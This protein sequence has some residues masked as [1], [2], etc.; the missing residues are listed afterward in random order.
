MLLVSYHTVLASKNNQQS[1]T[2]GA[3]P[4]RT[5]VAFGD[6]L[7]AGYGLP[8]GTA[9]PDVLGALLADA[10]LPVSIVNAGVSGDTSAGGKA[11]IAWS[12]A[13]KPDVL[14]LALGA[15]DGLQGL[16]PQALKQNLAAIIE[17]CLEDNV[18]V[19]L[20]GMLAPQ[21]MGEVYG[22]AFNAVYPE[23]AKTY[24]LPLYPFLLKGVALDPALNL[25]D[26]I[27]PNEAGARHIAENLLPLIAGTLRRPAP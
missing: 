20:A 3:I 14:I 25:E 18:Q 16:S 21:N 27:H 7:T 2:D 24:A 12:L 13:A 4:Q 23:L 15:N 1:E 9:W 8:A 6:S 22:N 5:V 19:I 10:G 26:G 11:R 17:A